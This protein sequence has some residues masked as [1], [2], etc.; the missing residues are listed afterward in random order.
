MKH[1]TLALI[2]TLMLST[3][4][5]AKNY[6]NDIA[7]EKA[8]LRASQR[9]VVE[10]TQD[11]REYEAKLE[12][13]REEKAR[14]KARGDYSRQAYES[15]AIGANKAAIKKNEAERYVGRKMVEEDREDLREERNEAR[16]DRYRGDDR[17]GNRNVR[18]MSP[19]AG[20]ESTFFGM[21]SQGMYSADARSQHSANLEYWQGDYNRARTGNR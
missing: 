6:N 15:M 14:A 13:N 3:T 1:V 8:E 12:Q 20:R 21:P 10:D 16:S 7:E 4:A 11:I 17:Y 5:Y 18:E 2:G 9:S 19:S